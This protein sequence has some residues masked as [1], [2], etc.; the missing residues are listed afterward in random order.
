MEGGNPRSL[1]S[2]QMPMTEEKPL[3]TP[4][5]WILT[6]AV[7]GAVL[8]AACGGGDQSSGGSS[9]GDLSGSI[10]ADGSSTVAPLTEAAAEL[11]MEENPNV[12]VT[13][14]TSGT[15][16]GFEK[17]CAGETDIA[18]ASRPI[19]DKEAEACKA[20]GIEFSE[21]TVANDALSVVVNPENTWAKC[22]K[23]DELKAIWQE[24]STIKSWKEVRA[25]F[26]DVPLELYGAGTDSGTFDYFTEV[27]NGE[28]GN[29]R[30][31]YQATEDDNVTVQGV[32]GKK[33]AMGYFGLSYALQNKDKVK[34]V[35][36]DGG[37]GCV[38]PSAEAVIDS[39][40]TPLGRPLFIYVSKT[41]LARAEVDAF[42]R[43]YLDNGDDIAEAALFIPLGAEQKKKA[44]D[45]LDA[46]I[47]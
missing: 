42:L 46:L 29:S 38:S 40:Y 3:S 45:D 2:A 23:V 32:G 34:T 20:K 17:F 28:T 37:S 4:R 41:A 15:G 33:G 21:L 25:G 26:P 5:S 39:T 11:F 27:V 8:T 36:I 10:R 18:D 6:I 16:G 9:G 12:R 19:K 7:A 13:V 30:T 44:V 22:L 47:G 31:D 35:D 43:F 1:S 24:G 14:G